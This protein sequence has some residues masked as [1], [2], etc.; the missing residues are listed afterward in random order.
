MPNGSGGLMPAVYLWRHLLTQGEKGFQT[1][2][3]SGGMEPFYPPP[4]DGSAVK[5]WSD[6]RVA[7][8]DVITTRAW[9][10]STKWYFAQRS[11]TARL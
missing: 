11:K 6:R 3:V 7:K 1:E 4:T 2:C 10:L 9:A 5:H 8:H